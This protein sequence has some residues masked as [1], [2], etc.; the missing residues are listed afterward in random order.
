MYVTLLHTGFRFCSSND[1]LRQILT[2]ELLTSE[3]NH[4]QR[5]SYGAAA[6]PA[7]RSVL[8]Q[9]VLRVTAQNSSLHANLV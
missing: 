2:C 5:G 9:I 1:F 7:A 4:L 3:F 6:A 8:D